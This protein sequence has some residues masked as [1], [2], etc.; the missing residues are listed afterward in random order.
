MP[1]KPNADPLLEQLPDVVTPTRPARWGKPA[2]RS[3]VILATIALIF[4]MDVAAPALLPVLIAGLLAML[5]NPV[6]RFL[7]RR[8]LPRALS[9]AIVLGVVLTGLG[10]AGHIAYAPAMQAATESPRLVSKIKHKVDS[11]M[12]STI[13]PAEAVGEA[14]EAIDAIGAEQ[15]P[16]AIAVMQTPLGISERFGGLLG[17]LASAAT[18]IILVYLFLVYGEHLFRRIVIIAPTL[19]DKRKTVSI[20]REVQQDVSRYVGTITLI[21]IGL[22]GAV[23]LAMYLL[24]VSD[25]LLWGV[26][27]TLVNYVPYVG[28]MAGGAL[29]L[30]FGIIEFNDPLSAMLP[31]A[32]YLGLNVIESQLVTPMVLGR[33]FALN[34]LVILVWLL[35][36]GWLW[37]VAGLLLA[38]PLLV[39]AKIICSR[40]E[41]LRPWALMIER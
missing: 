37:G 8:W 41:T 16:R 35:F 22:G 10:F 19:A 5:L 31:A 15:K 40:S 32:C 33:N 6:V 27:A 36:L 29:L 28:P 34:P 39:C 13:S 23:S 7:S 38:L 26:M 14:L 3:L 21:N 11:M 24:G 18:S 25:P 30:A 20:V 1:P 2:A 4:A 17:I 9:A 12:R